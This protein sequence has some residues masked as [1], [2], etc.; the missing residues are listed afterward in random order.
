MPRYPWVEKECCAYIVHYGHVYRDGDAEMGDDSEGEGV[1]FQTDYDFPR[2]A[3]DLGW[4]LT[5][6][7]VRGD[8][9][10]HHARHVKGCDHSGTDGT[11]TC[12]DCGVTVGDFIDAAR[13]YLDF[14]AGVACSGF[15]MTREIEQ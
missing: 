2:A 5:R 13:E 12:R 8:K 3:Q 15:G 10:R 14:R 11:V 1:L 9:V 4:R 7:Q 6:V